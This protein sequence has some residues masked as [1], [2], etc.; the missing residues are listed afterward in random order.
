MQVYVIHETRVLD[1]KVWIYAPSVKELE[2]Y[3]EIL[4]KCIGFKK[5]HIIADFE[6]IEIVKFKKNCEAAINV[7][8]VC[9][10]NIQ[11]IFA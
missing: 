8:Y 11:Y 2:E 9:S 5:V 7:L 10:S 1:D 3:I 6:A 4:V